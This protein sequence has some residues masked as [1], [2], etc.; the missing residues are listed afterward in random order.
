[1]KRY[2]L[3]FHLVEGDER[4]ARAFCE[5]INANLNAY[6]RRRYPAHYTP[7]LIR[8]NYGKGRDWNGFI[9]WFHD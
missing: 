8:D 1:M 3:R 6:A 2:R 7:H 5:R 4:E 9:C